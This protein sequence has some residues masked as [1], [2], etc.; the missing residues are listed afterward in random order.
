MRTKLLPAGTGFPWLSR[1]RPGQEPERLEL[2]DFPFT[3]GRNETC[4]YRVPS[5]RVSREHAEIVRDGASYRLRDLGSTNGTFV[6]GQRI[7]EVRL[8]DGDVVVFADVEFCFY[9]GATTQARKTVTQLMEPLAADESCPQHAGRDLIHA[10]RAQHEAL[11]H[12]A[13]RNRF[14]PVMDLVDGRCIG[15]E[16]TGRPAEFPEPTPGQRLLAATEC[17]LTERTAYV[18][19]LVAAE[20]VAKLPAG[21]LLFVNLQPAEVGADALPDS[22]ARLARL[23]GGKR[24][25]AEIPDS[26]VVDI[27]YF[28]DFYQRL[29]ALGVGVAYDGFAGSLHQ[30]RAQQAYVPDFVKLAAA[31]ARGVDRST[32][33]QQQIRD[34]VQ[35]SRELSIEL[36]A[37]GVHTENEAQ[38]CRELGVRLGQG[39]HFGRARTIDWPIESWQ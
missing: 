39:E 5:S 1:E 33:R 37:D 8:S 32:Q 3:V 25:V 13:V 36:I 26:A 21:T 24:I 34:L 17:R 19:R 20:H 4:D 10:V 9:S 12:R 29:R 15:Y 31:L 38:T 22:L 18:H 14:Q 11:L 35:A 23:A 28:R 2:D 30:I 16:A 27:P 6:N 7:E